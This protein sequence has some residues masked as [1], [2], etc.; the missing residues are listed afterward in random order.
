MRTIEIT[1]DELRG[2]LRELPSTDVYRYRTCRVA[3]PRAISLLGPPTDDEEFINLKIVT[4]RRQDF[5][6]GK[7]RRYEWLLTIV[8]EG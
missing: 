8:D 5:G 2:V 3:I 6:K 4:F 1:A 7:E